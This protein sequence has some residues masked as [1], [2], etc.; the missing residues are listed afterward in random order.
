M[1][2]RNVERM[3]ASAALPLA[4]VRVL[5]FSWSLP[6]PYATKLLADLGAE[7]D[8]VDL[9]ARPEIFRT[10][11]PLADDVSCAWRYVNQNKRRRL[12]NHRDQSDVDAIVKEIGEY[13][14]LVEQFRPGAMEAWGLGYE[15]L[16]AQHPRR[17][18]L[19]RARTRALRKTL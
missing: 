8:A 2:R 16:S 9:T 7:I 15:T 4:G 3:D 19:G 18:H 1:K 10:L 14:I 6:G 12:I 17:P 5:D 11:P 13:D